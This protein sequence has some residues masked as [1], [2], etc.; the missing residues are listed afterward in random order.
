M[1]DSQKKSKLICLKTNFWLPHI[2]TSL[3][4]K[5]FVS[6]KERE[7]MYRLWLPSRI[8]LYLVNMNVIYISWQIWKIWKVC[9]KPPSFHKFCYSVKLGRAMWQ[10]T[11][12]ILLFVHSNMFYQGSACSNTIGGMLQAKLKVWWGTA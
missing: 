8:L 9:I 6:K 12:V 3:L 11:D 10:K 7:G 5:V 1:Y 2:C 4:I